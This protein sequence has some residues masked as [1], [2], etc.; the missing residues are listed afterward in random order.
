MNPISSIRHNGLFS[1]VQRLVPWLCLALL[2][3]V[4]LLQAIRGLDLTDT[5][6]VATNQQLFFAAPQSVAYW[7]HLWL[8]NLLGGL[9]YL[10]FGQWGLLPM[11]LAAAVIFW[12]TILAMYRLYRE[13]VPAILILLG[14]ACGMPF[15]FFGKINIVHYNNLSTLFLVWGVFFLAKGVLERHTGH[16]FMAGF[17]LAVNTFVRLPN[18][19]AIGFIV[20]IPLFNLIERDK[21]KRLPCGVKEYLAYLA[22]CIAAVAIV[23]AVMTILGQRELYFNALRDLGSSTVSEGSHYKW[24]QII[25]RPLFDVLHSL[26]YGGGAIALV[27]L[28]SALFSW[29]RK[30]WTRAVVVFLAACLTCMFVAQTGIVASFRAKLYFVVA[31]M[32]YWAV[33]YVFFGLRKTLSPYLR[34]AFL[35]A[36]CCVLVLNVGSDTGI[37]VSTYAF[38][39]VLIAVFQAFSSVGRERRAFRYTVAIVVIALSAIGLV[40]IRDDVYRDTAKFDAQVHDSALAGIFT[41]A[42]R[43]R[44]LEKILPVIRSFAPQDSDVLMADSIGLLHFATKTR[45]WLGNPWPVLWTDPE[46]DLHIRAR[47][48]SGPLP[49]V[50]LTTLNPRG[51]GW[52][53]EGREPV[54]MVP[55]RSF[56]ARHSYLLAWH[57]E[58]MEI[59]TPQG[60]TKVGK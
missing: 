50:V 29:L 36:A 23:L 8:T 59:W 43:A 41:S 2:A 47:E 44:E 25:K 6:F 26:V 52:P 46:L 24:R 5:G 49:P 35:L 21:A 34:L 19:I 13:E 14:A 10:A 11:K 38:P 1:R 51:P 18:V 58:V 17:L 45:P 28:L 54:G 16:M 15:D 55:I 56:L 37:S 33:L 9:V 3:V 39:L 20:L 30:T 42:A 53:V 48:S 57:D 32:G 7:F 4:P 22:G 60:T 27:L 31:G 12:L 40:A